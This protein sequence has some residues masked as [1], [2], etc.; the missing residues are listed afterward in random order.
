[1]SDLISITTGKATVNTKQVA[2]HF[3]LKGGHR[4]VM[5]QVRSIIESS[6]DEG[7][8][9]GVQNYLRSS[10]RSLQNKELECYEMTRDG[11]AILAMGFTGPEAMKWKKAYIK[12][13]NEMEEMLISVKEH[14]VMQKLSDAIEIMEKDKS[15][16]SQFGSG[17][18][19][20][21]KIRS[22]HIEKV[23]KL[24]SEAQLLL[25]F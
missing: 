20:W 4:Y 11:F 21:K 10:Y 8:D 15:V 25:K 6:K 3:R 13:F 7:D 5:S 22:G 23:N 18:N 12:A 1:M 9:F 2:D 14:S 24:M 17:L 16:A 19:E